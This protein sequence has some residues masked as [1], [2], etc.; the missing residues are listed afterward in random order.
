MTLPG[1]TSRYCRL[2]KIT[3][4]LAVPE[5]LKSKI[6]IRIVHPGSITSK[7]L[8]EVRPED[9]EVASVEAEVVLVHEVVCHTSV[10]TA[11]C[12][13]DADFWSEQVAAVF[14]NH[15]DHPQLY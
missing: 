2:P 1:F 9:E 14:S 13:Y 6:N 7:C 12:D 15:T 11:Q 10:Q 5:T 4:V 3:S 8:S